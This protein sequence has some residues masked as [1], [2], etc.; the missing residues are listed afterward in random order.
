MLAYQPRPELWALVVGIVLAYLGA[1]HWHARH[2]GVRVSPGQ[3]GVLPAGVLVLRAALDWPIDDSTTAPCCPGPHLRLQRRPGLPGV[4][5]AA[6]AP[7]IDAVADQQ[8]AGVVMK[9]GGGLL[10]WLAI[11]I[12]SSAGPAR[13]R[14]PC[15]LG[16][17]P[18]DRTTWGRVD[19]TGRTQAL[20]DHPA[21]LRAPPRR[22]GSGQV[23]T[24]FPREADRA[25]LESLE[26][27]KVVHGSHL[28]L[29][30]RANGNAVNP[31]QHLAGRPC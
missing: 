3:A 16:R 15:G 23:H 7:G 26:V 8:I 2:T 21:A 5:A 29:Q 22:P 11:V 20:R 17:A 12:I 18:R 10:L 9:I 13:R 4:C 28:R 30:T 25:T 27:A 19:L 6:Q 14:P 31:R 24:P 1:H